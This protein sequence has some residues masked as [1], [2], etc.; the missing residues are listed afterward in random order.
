MY[1]K[2]SVYGEPAT[3]S[4]QT[5]YLYRRTNSSPISTQ[6]QKHRL[7]W[8]GHVLR[9]PQ[10]SIPKVALRWT[11]TGKRNRGRPKTTWRRTITT[12]LSDI[13]LTMGEAQVIAQD[14]HRWRRDI[15][16]LCPTLG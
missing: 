7:R 9:I 10:D 4:G 3:Y 14:R 12:E 11:P 1:S 16:A 8:L 6:I 5:R 13:G 2:P 15:V